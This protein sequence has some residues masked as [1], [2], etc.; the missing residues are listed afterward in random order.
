MSYRHDM[1]NVTFLQIKI[2][3]FPEQYTNTSYL[4]NITSP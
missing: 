2:T 4:T 1:P 3:L